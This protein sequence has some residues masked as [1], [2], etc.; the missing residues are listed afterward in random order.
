MRS[1]R[2]EIPAGV[3]K[4]EADKAEVREAQ[5]ADPDTPTLNAR[6]G[7]G[8]VLANQIRSVRTN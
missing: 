7:C 1:D 3:D 2:E 5:L 6:P 8:G 4:V